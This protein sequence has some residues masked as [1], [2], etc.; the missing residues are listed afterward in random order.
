LKKAIELNPNMVWAHYY[1][2]WLYELYG[3][4]WKEASLA[5]GDRTLELN[6]LPPFFV[7]G[8]AWQYADACRYKEALRLAEEAIRL[9]PEHPLGRVSL[10]MIHADMG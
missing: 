8:L 2:A 9:D 1:L 3:P 6:P 7:A 4:V 10:G 5:A